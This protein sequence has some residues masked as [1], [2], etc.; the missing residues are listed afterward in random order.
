M[1]SLF[2]AVGRRKAQDVRFYRQ[3]IVA[4]YRTPWA[5][6]VEV[7]ETRAPTKIIPAKPEG[8]RHGMQQEQLL[9]GIAT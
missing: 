6:A 2:I 9:S 8:N 1:R 3:S 5:I 4:D 7:Q